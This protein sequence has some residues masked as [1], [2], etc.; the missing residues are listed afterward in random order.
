M[1]QMNN[2]P[3][4]DYGIHN[5]ASNIR[6]H[7]APY[8]KSV[9]I[10]PTICA[11]R[12]ISQNERKLRKVS[13]YQPGVASRT[14]E[15]FLVRPCDVENLRIIRLSDTRVSTFCDSM[16]TT[17]KGD[18]AVDVVQCLLK[19]GRFPLWFEGDFATDIATQITGTDVIACGKWKIEV[20]CDARASEVA[21]KPDD[22]CSGFLFM[23]VAECNPLRRH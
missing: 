8:A 1:S 9:F 6:A 16:T 15:G 22:R 5:E 11:K 3:L 21:R 12:Y 18:F 19:A 13:G 10:F 2:L 17:E 20:K 4:F 7:V 23:Q 14:S